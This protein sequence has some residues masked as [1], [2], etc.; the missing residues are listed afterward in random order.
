M[1]AGRETAKGYTPFTDTVRVAYA[2]NRNTY[3][4]AT[5]DAD[6]EFSRWLSEHDAATLSPFLAIAEAHRN[7]AL[8]TGYDCKCELCRAAEATRRPISEADVWPVGHPEI[9]AQ[10]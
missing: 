5:T 1:S 8:A 3:L 6:A 7:A 9:D 4:P 2:N 10:P